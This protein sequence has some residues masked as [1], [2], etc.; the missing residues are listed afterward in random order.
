M[1]PTEQA[2][3]AAAPAAAQEQ[4]QVEELLRLTRPMDDKERQRNKSYLE[5]FLR[6]VVQPGQVVSKDVETNIKYWI[7]ETDKKLS[8]QLNEIM[9]H[10]DF[11]HLEA[12]W[13]GL[14]YLVHET[15]GVENLKIRVFNA[16]KREL[17]R[18]LER[19]PEFDQSEL[20]KK[21]YEAEYGQLG[22]KPYGLLVGDYEF[23]RT[24]ED[25]AM[26]KMVSEV[27]GAAH[28]PFVAGASPKLFNFDR[29]TDL[30]APAIW[31]R[32]SPASSTRPGSPSASRR[33]R[34][35]SL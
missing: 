1:S 21:V 2:A 26:L 24:A 19:A 5:E 6:K 28:A 33:P 3:S 13:R 35:T 22:G 17:F 18:D 25:V 14:H 12:T 10:E 11:Q 8:A 31:P 23:G 30:T 32:S 9:H 27:A 29:F 20:F 7:A 4:D 15:P 16:T 34:A